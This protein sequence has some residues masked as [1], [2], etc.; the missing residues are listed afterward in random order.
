MTGSRQYGLSRLVRRTCR[1]PSARTAS[2]EAGMRTAPGRM[3]G[4]FFAAA[5]A[6][7]VV[8]AGAAFFTDAPP[9]ARAGWW[10]RVALPAGGR[11]GIGG[12]HPEGV[13]QLERIRDRRAARGVVED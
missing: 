10:S 3:R 1:L 12:P 6:E 11:S 13:A 2:P 8:F 4:A 7:G 9:E 5:I